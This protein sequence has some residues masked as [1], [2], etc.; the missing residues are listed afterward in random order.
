MLMKKFLYFTLLLALGFI[1][2]HVHAQEN[3][4]GKWYAEHMKNAIVEIAENEEGHLYGK[5]IVSDKPQWIG[6]IVLRKL[7][8]QADKQ[9]WEGEI[10]SPQRKMTINGVI[11]LEEEGKL[12]LVGTKFLMT[13]TFYWER[14]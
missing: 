14:R 8:Y 3:I 7:A 4:N 10:Y 5:I 11:S 1:K 2:V 13:K 6:E 12:K 9:Q